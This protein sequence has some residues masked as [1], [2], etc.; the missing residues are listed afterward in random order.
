[1]DGFE[2]T[3]QIRDPANGV[4][5]PTVQIIAMTANVMKGDRESCLAVGMNDYL[6]KPVN[7]RE[8]TRVLHAALAH[9]RESDTRT[10]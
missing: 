2:A 9:R 5:D 7:V 3:K 1:M 6:Q 8:L 4:L 10:Y